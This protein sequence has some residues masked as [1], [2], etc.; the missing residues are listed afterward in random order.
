[1]GI[2]ARLLAAGLV[3]CAAAVA[4]P[5]RAASAPA[6]VEVARA[7]AETLQANEDDGEV[8]ISIAGRT[9]GGCGAPDAGV[10]IVAGVP[11]GVKLVGV[12]APAAAASLEVRRAGVLLA[13]A[14]TEAGAAYRGVG[15]GS[16]RF[17]LLRLPDTAPI[18]GLRVHALDAAGSLIAVLADRDSELVIARRR[19]LSG[20][21]AGI[22][23][24]L[25]TSQHSTLSRSVLD[26]ARET[27]SRCVRTNAQFGDV[28]FSTSSCASG[29]PQAALEVFE[30]EES[31]VEEH[32]PG[33]RLLHG[34][35][36]GP[37][38]V[39]VVLADGRRRAVRT[40]DVGD[41]WQ[42]YA[43]TTG[44]AAV[45]A[46]TLTTP[47]GVVR[48]LSRGHAPLA[49]KCAAGEASFW[50]GFTAAGPFDERSVV[51]PATPPAALAGPPAFRVADGPGDTLCLALG[52]Q[53]FRAAGCAIVSPRIGELH[54]ALD[55][56][57]DPH[58]FAL[59]VPAQVMT[60]RIPTPDGKGVLS[61]PTDPGADYTGRYAGRVRFAAAAVARPSQLARIELLDAAGGVLSG[62]LELAVAEEASSLLGVLRFARPRRVAGRAGSPSLWKTTARFQGLP[63]RCLAM[64]DGAAPTGDAR[65]AV[66]S[67]GAA[68]L[69]DAS[70]LPRR[71]SVAV[72][73]RPGTRAFA[74]VG[75]SKPRRLRLRN[76]IGL[77]T[78]PAARPL[79]TLTFIRRGR[80]RRVR[81]SAP[82]AARQ[83]GW[84]AARE[85]APS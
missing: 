3:L 12:A 1:M 62:R 82:P 26:P 23:W 40:V 44:V 48:V 78:L 84:A 68:I 20:R 6:P 61:I 63:V 29:P 85:I 47:S 72:V 16:L 27:V 28:S 59:A 75:T 74:G 49:T 36:A 21:S 69:L 10:V 56:P 18:A 43:V 52:E 25:T 83:C 5:A 30:H 65:C 46:V 4:T 53:P 67:D 55:S 15:A 22:R 45:R 77:L 73:T 7:G 51:S 80:V 50:S 39:S 41:G 19:L 14:P 76:G 38:R 81:I 33:F 32:C 31:A 70:C 8:C 34:V 9:A 17:A 13:S 57:A 71:L 37:A 79:R 24:S 60:V 54:G 42:A 66:A 35:V 2:R 64:T 58:A 11:G